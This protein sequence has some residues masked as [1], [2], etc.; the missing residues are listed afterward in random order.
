MYFCSMNTV[1]ALY[2]AKF[3]VGRRKIGL[4]YGVLSAVRNDLGVLAY[5][6]LFVLFW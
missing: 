3:L 4:C 2:L 5:L 6:R 1:A